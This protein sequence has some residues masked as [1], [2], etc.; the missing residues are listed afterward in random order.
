ME[1]GDI[2]CA[3]AKDVESARGVNITMLNKASSVLAENL[4]YL[5]EGDGEE[6]KKDCW[7][8]Y[9]HYYLRWHIYIMWL[10][11]LNDQR[12]MNS[13]L[14]MKISNAINCVFLCYYNMVVAWESLHKDCECFSNTFL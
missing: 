10:L 14:S 11:A 4:S 2:E 6:K 3:H 9:Y 13:T 1:F 5:S 7:F 8:H 12:S